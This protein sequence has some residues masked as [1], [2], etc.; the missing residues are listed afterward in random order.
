MGKSRKQR[1]GVLGG[2]FDPVHYGHLIL[3]EQI[4]TEACLDEILFVPAYVSPFKIWNRPCEADHR[5]RMLELAI[6]DHEGFTISTIELEKD[7]PS[8]T[9]DTLCALRDEYGSGAELHFIL[10]TDSFLSIEEWNESEKL[11]SEFS[12]LIGLR[13]GYDEERLKAV[14]LELSE[15]Y[16]LKA[17]YIPIPE[18][19]ISAS[20]LRQRISSG[21]SVRFLL[22]D[23]VI[24]YIDEQELYD[25][26]IHRVREFA[27]CRMDSERLSHTRGVVRKAIQLAHRHGADPEKAEIAGWLHDAYRTCGDLEHAEAAA[28]ALQEEFDIVDE[29]IEQAIRYHTTGRAGMGLLEKIL[30]VAD[31]LEE[32]RIYPGVEALRQLSDTDL[33]ECLYR[34]ML[35]SKNYI[36]AAGRN[37]HPSTEA[38][39]REL[40]PK[41]TKEV[42]MDNQEIAL[43]IAKTLYEKKG[44]EIVLL[45][46]SL[47]SGFADYFVIVTANN[48]RHVKSLVND[49]EKGLLLH[50]L[51]VNHIEGHEE[52]GWVLMDYGDV[53]V[54]VFTEEQRSHY[55]IE[56]IWNDCPAVDHPYQD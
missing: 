14:L 28:R 9:Y 5:L 17:T 30:Y 53:V 48:V 37:V 20:D 52:S 35:A 4:K 40:A 29:E 54:N 19:E 36:E 43:A 26:R 22:P 21:K 31:A 12:F 55:Q 10:G 27:K 39:L 15:K 41:G 7:S 25:Q 16:P 24:Q 2:S 47:K 1:I 3:A 49:V 38:A 50:D 6:D 18:L 34:T 8:Y 45:D 56:R 32:G 23:A 11:L 51:S 46:I 42:T 13:R 44:E 33:D